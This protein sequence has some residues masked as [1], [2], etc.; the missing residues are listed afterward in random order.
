MVLLCELYL[1]WCYLKSFEHGQQTA[2][3]WD[4]NLTK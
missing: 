4:I 2:E 1:R 3:K